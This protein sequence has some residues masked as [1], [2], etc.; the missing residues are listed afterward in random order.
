MLGEKGWRELIYQES[1]LHRNL[2]IC[3]MIVKITQTKKLRRDLLKKKKSNLSLYRKD[4]FF[5][6]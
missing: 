3:L 4:S 1:E 5:A 2:E 6:I